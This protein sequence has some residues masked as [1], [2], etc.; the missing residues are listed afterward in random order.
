MELEK[1]PTEHWWEELKKAVY[2]AEVKQS[3]FDQRIASSVPALPSNVSLSK[4]LI[5]MLLLVVTD[6]AIDYI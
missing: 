4:T 6:G 2:G 1:N 3:A 5:S